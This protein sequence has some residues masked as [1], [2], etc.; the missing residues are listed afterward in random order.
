MKTRRAKQKKAKSKPEPFNKGYLPLTDGHTMY[1]EELGNP[2]G[3]PIVWLHG[4]PGGSCSRNAAKYFHLSHWRLIIY[5]Q[6]GCGKSTPFGVD[7]LKHNTT[8]D[9][10]A[11]L[12][13]LRQHLCI[14]KWTVIGGSWG[15]TLGIAYAETHPSRVASMML[16]G[17]CIMEPYEYSWLY[18]KTG[19]ANVF[20]EQWEKFIEPLPVQVRDKGY[21]TIMKTYRKLLTSKNAKTRRNAAK[22][23]WGWEASVNLLE[24]KPNHTP[25]HKAESLGIIENHYFIH[26]AWMKPHQLLKDAP[27]LKDIPI[28]IIHGRY[29]LVCPVR[30]AWAFHKAAPHSKLIIM[31][32]SG[33]ITG[34]E[35]SDRRIV[36]N[37]IHKLLDI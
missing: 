27:K 7:S 17:V 22:H 16:R 14:D 8:W 28:T 37:E 33:H 18:E 35:P 36:K 24:P 10:V 3:K 6:R 13:L 1:F 34:S 9:L 4:G 23:C 15:T 30:S 19:S 2:K 32:R 11:D 31:P 20:P 21:G 5:D 25:E 12:E 29:D 26:N